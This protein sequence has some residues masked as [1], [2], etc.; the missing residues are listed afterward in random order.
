MLDTKHLDDLVNRFCDALPS[1]VKE[2]KDD[3]E[4]NFKSAVKGAFEKMDLVSREEFDAQVKVLERTREK[5]DALEKEL[6]ASAASTKSTTAKASKAK[7]P[8][9]KE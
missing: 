7:K 2:F 6:K 8:K 3:V 4:E 5:L 1:A 9:S